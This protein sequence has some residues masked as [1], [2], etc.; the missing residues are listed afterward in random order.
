MFEVEILIDKTCLSVLG[1]KLQLDTVFPLTKL[2]AYTGF[3][4]RV[5]A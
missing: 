5:H 1:G 3:G 2:F 4:N